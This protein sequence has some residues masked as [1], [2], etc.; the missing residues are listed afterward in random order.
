MEG[1][2]VW[3]GGLGSLHT[4]SLALSQSAVLT[5]VYLFNATL[6]PCQARMQHYRGVALLR[7]VTYAE[8]GN[9][10]HYPGQLEFAKY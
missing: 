7:R 10:K 2:R 3:V 6:K 9:G 4:E 8:P 1:L 5:V